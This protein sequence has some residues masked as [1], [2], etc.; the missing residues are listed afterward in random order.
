MKS[1]MVFVS[2]MMIAIAAVFAGNGQDK[3]AEEIKWYT[4]EEADSL[5]QIEKR[6]VYIDIYTDWCGWCKVMDKKT[7]TD[8]EVID[9]LNTEFY[10]V[11]LDG[12][13]KHDITFRD[14]TYQYVQSG[15]GG[16]HELA[17]ALLN[18]KMSYP[19]SVL[20]DENMN[21]IQPLPGYM[22][23]EKLTPILEFIG[24]EHYKN[25]TWEEFTAK[26]S[27]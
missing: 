1:M 15:R 11:K 20:L 6:K 5:Q 25:T 19:T 3:A 27:Q 13:A 17:A 10:A 24:K 4:I 26:K 7:F 18:G 9:L 16:Y 2:A 14:K 23:P 12:E 21:M 8:P 22:P